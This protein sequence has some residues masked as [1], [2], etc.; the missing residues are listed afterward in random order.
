MIIAHRGVH[1]NKDIPENSIMAFKKAIDKE[2]A[3]EFDIEITKDSKLVIH[4]DD[5]LKRMT[6]INKKTE[7]MTL[8]EIKK[9]KLLATDEVIPTFK[10][11]LDLVNVK[12]FLDIEIKSTKRVKEVVDLVLKE[13]EDYK[14]LVQL[15]S[16]D[17][18]I[19]N[20]LKK[21]TNKYKIGLLL[22]RNSPNKGLNFLV[23][24]GLI[25]KTPFDFLAVDKKMLDDRY[26]NKY[27]DKYPLFAWT[28]DGLDE[29]SIY[30]EKYPKIICI[31]NYL[32]K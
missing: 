5:N 14:G 12:V 26:Y 23:K 18:F 9:L 29:A 4:H 7:D 2:Y 30:L 25:Y 15:K 28:F 31:C 8:D 13:L 21:T 19:V 24:A 32:D 16:F 22:M 20:R 11:V 3:I 27:I 6:N 1:N 10:E 17:P